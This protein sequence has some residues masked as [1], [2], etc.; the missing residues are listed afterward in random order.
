MY[1]HAYDFSYTLFPSILGA[2]LKPK[3]QNQIVT[4]FIMNTVLQSV[5]PFNFP[6][7]GLGRVLIS[8]PLPPVSIVITMTIISVGWKWDFIASLQYCRIN[9]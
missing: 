8:L 5:A 4:S 2:Y 7:T 9:F 3:L 6:A 1:I